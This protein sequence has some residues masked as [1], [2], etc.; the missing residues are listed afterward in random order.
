MTR[1]RGIPTAAPHL[2]GQPV[3]DQFLLSCSRTTNRQTAL[4][5]AVTNTID[6]GHERSADIYCCEMVRK[7][8]LVLATVSSETMAAA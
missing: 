3:D 5:N 4:T 8:S 2:A 1:Q 7:A 6:S